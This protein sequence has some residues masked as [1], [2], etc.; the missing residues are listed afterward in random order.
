MKKL[1]TLLIVLTSLNSFAAYHF[2]KGA[3][4]W[5][6][7]DFLVYKAGWDLHEDASYIG[8]DGDGVISSCRLRVDWDDEAFQEVL[9]HT[10]P[11]M[12]YATLLKD[13]KPVAYVAF[14]YFKFYFTSK[15]CFYKRSF[16]Y[17]ALNGYDLTERLTYEQADW[18]HENT[19]L[20]R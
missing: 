2:K 18:F 15:P 16:R 1:L 3:P 13:K 14:M 6:N 5:L 19:P 7:E 10:Q 11:S 20:Y 12:S 8:E 17:I 9:Y 4:S